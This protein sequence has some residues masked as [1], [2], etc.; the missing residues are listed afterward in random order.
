MKHQVST[1]SGALLDAAV[2]KVKGLPYRIQHF[3]DP[4]TRNQGSECIIEG[5]EAKYPASTNWAI[6]GPLL[7][8]HLIATAPVKSDDGAVQ[9]AAWDESDESCMAGPDSGGY[10]ER[11]IPVDEPGI[12]PTRLI[13]ACRA[14]VASKLGAEVD[15]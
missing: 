15:L 4:M 8:A 13:A 14:L 2:A 11:G 5:L 3:G 7:D 12:G 6:G 10:F 9:W 1:L